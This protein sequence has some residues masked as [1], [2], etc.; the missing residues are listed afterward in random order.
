MLLVSCISRDVRD[1]IFYCCCH[2]NNP[3]LPQCDCS[4]QSSSQEKHLSPAHRALFTHQQK[5]D[6]MGMSKQLAGEHL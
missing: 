4:R 3:D 1:D 5:A 2:H 6:G